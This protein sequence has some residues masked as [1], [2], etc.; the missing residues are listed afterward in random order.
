MARADEWS[1]LRREI[2]KAQ[3]ERGPRNRFDE[4]LRGRV[5]EAVRERLEAGES[6][7][8]LRRSLGLGHSTLTEWMTK[9]SVV[10]ADRRPAAWVPVVVESKEPG[11]SFVLELGSGRI[12]GLALEDV[13]ELV[14]R[15]R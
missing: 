10:V 13:V 4:R 8:A 12:T 11:R 2:G 7:A 1:V 3:R 6:L 5:V 9:S 15:L 14:R